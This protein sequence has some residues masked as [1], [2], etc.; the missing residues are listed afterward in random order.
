MAFLFVM[1]LTI[2][3]FLLQAQPGSIENQFLGNP[4]IPPEAREILRARL[5]LNRPLWG[6]YT[7]F[8]T[9]FF[10][11]DF[12]VSWTEY[13]REVTS[14]LISRLPRT[15]VLFMTATLSAYWLGFASGKLVAWKRGTRTEHTVT[16][17]GIFLYTVFYPWFALLMLWIFAANLGWFP[18]GKFITPR[19]WTDSPFTANQVFYRMIFVALAYAV[20]LWIVWAVTYRRVGDIER[21]K[22]VR[23]GFSA[24]GIAASVLYFFVFA[25]EM[26]VYAHGIVHHTTLPVITLTLVFFAQITLLTRSSML[27]TLKEDYILTARAKGIPE[28]VIRDRHAARNALLPVTTSFVLALAAVIGGGIV[29]ESIFSW[30]G[31]GLTLL[32]AVLVEDIPV[33]IGGLALIG[34]LSLMG[35][36]I[37][38]ILYTFL[39]PRIRYA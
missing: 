24:V 11:L 3:F 30:P 35:H 15:V 31:I 18:V 28:R 2:I 29:T 37:V 21:R 9:N 6:Q 33:A 22:W 1:F 10:Q 36:L 12:G 19:I 20:Y 4:E 23:R 8:I 26:R 7:S 32:N 34:A 14:I 5:G 16:V 38:D 25:T 13:P 17:T 27:E 39:D